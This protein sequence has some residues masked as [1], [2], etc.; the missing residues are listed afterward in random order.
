MVPIIWSSAEPSYNEDA[1]ETHLAILQTE[2]R[3]SSHRRCSSLGEILVHL[4]N[5]VRDV[6]VRFVEEIATLLLEEGEGVLCALGSLASL[7]EFRVDGAESSLRVA[8]SMER[9]RE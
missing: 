1:V 6:R 7:V 9:E 3:D 2:V 4:V 8:E 5:L